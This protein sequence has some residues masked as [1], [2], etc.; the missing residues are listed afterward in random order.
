[1]IQF[2]STLNASC[3]CN[4]DN[5]ACRIKDANDT[6]I[7]PLVHRTFLL[8]KLLRNADTSVDALLG[9]IRQLSAQNTG[10]QFT[11]TASLAV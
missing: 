2:C 3:I 10:C 7:S 9:N 11:Q 4:T 8:V 1:M 6:A 5:K